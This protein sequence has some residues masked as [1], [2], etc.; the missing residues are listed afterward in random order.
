MP[1][2]IGISFAW[3]KGCRNDISSTIAASAEPHMR[4]GAPDDGCE[5][6]R[7]ILVTGFVEVMVH[8][9]PLWR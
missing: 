5:V 6:Q 8:L 7:H 9:L 3:L 1:Y 2:A 4:H